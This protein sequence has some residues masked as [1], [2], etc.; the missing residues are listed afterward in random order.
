MNDDTFKFGRWYIARRGAK[1]G[2]FSGSELSEYAQRDQIG[3]DELVWGPGL[4][5]W[6][7]AGDVPGLF[8]PPP[9]P[10]DGA[11]SP[12]PPHIPPPIEPPPVPPAVAPAA[13]PVASA[14][15][16]SYLV[17]HWRGDLSLA[18]SFWVNGFLFN[19][20][21]GLVLG[22]VSRLIEVD[23]DPRIVLA[24]LIFVWLLLVSVSTWQVVGTW[25]SAGHHKARGGRAFWAVLTRIV[26]VLG[27]LATIGN[28]A[29]YAVPSILEHID[30]VT[31]D[32]RVGPGALRLLRDGTE[33]ELT[34][35]ITFGEA[36][37]L[38]K[39]LAGAPKVRVVHLNSHGG[40]VLEGR[41]LRDIIR[42][43]GL[44]TYTSTECDSACTIAFLGGRERYIDRRA[45]LGFHAP[46]ARGVPRSALAQIVDED[47]AYLARMGVPR[48]FVDRVYATPTTSVW[49]PTIAQL[50]DARII[51]GV[52]DRN[53]FALS[54]LEAFRTPAK[55]EALLM[56]N[57]VYAAIRKADA[58]AFEQ[59]RRDWT[60]GLENGV[61]EAALAAKTRAVI[62]RVL[63]AQLPRA[64]DDSV[65]E[66][67]N[68]LVDE[69]DAISRQDAA[70]C[71][72][73]LF[74]EDSAVPVD[75]T[76][77]FTA[78]LQQRDARA[79]VRAIESGLA[80]GAAI[81][82]DAAAVPLIQALLARLRGRHG[83][84]IDALASRDRS[85]LD[86]AA[87]CPL[88]IS[89]Y[90]EALR[91]PPPKHVL[92]LRYMFAAGQRSPAQ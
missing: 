19:F 90:R 17:R 6:V 78:E 10:T 48:D 22:M 72:F 23:Y 56:K 88:M 62:A 45:R 34:G 43:H 8:E 7:R 92:L 36:A 59:V 74:P 15:R 40:R 84:A 44:V 9:L 57:P 51:T 65:V 60:E 66:M 77:Y 18:R 5:D 32:R 82:A 79:T 52:A 39:M 80:T 42:A 63:Q 50:K 30:I 46:E 83:G 85:R 29:R 73:F 54:G 27:V 33:I 75:L 91:L 37:A 89:F 81:P 2:P 67:T 35:G 69:M 58:A 26:I 49:Y 28:I 87:L 13:P 38:E 21:L 41:R 16:G 3:R 53:A 25:R 12:N 71:Y 68:L 11:E 14:G 64:A 20:V 1:Y 47:R 4:L 55:I 86:R 70:A 61:T 24:W 76:R 31:G